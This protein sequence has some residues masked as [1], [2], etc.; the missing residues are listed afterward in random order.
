MKKGFVFDLDGVITDTAKFHYIAWKDLAKNLGITI[1]EAFNETLKGISRM[2][3]LD[4]ILTYGN[5]ENDFTLAE[6]EALAQ[7]KNDE[8]VKL[9]ADLSAED[10][11]PG[12]HDFLVQA[13]EN[14]IPCAIA[15][16]SKNAP[17][18]LEKLGVLDFFGHIVDPETL[19]KGKPD[20]E[21]FVKAAESINVEPKDAIGFED[22]QAGIEGIKAAGM[23]AVGISE[24][25]TLSG[26]D[27]QVASMTEL[28]VE[29]FMHI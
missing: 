14:N 9:L 23:Y 17:M 11:L 12:V 27:L 7:T 25:E 13:K 1:D 24:T 20:P 19:K 10:L 16:A 29:Q 22:A 21:I 2:D 18:I 6:K 4:K 28:S 5:R 15:S 8:Y 3:S 26:A